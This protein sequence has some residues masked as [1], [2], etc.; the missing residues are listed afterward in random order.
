MYEGVVLDEHLPF[1]IRESFKAKTLKVA[2]ADKA[3]HEVNSGLGDWTRDQLSSDLLLS[4]TVQAIETTTEEIRTMHAA[5]NSTGRMVA[6]AAASG[7]VS[8]VVQLVRLSAEVGVNDYRNYRF[9]HTLGRNKLS[10]G[11]KIW[12][13]F[14]IC[15]SREISVSTCYAIFHPRVSGVD[16]FEMFCWIFV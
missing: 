13:C 14:M 5:G 16:E 15:E 4:N 7:V 10:W 8:E 3:I 11:R 2:V 9:D 12:T 6:T 1:T